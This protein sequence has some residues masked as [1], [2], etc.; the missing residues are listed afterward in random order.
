MELGKTTDRRDQ[1]TS[2]V[3]ELEE[4][5]EKLEGGFCVSSTEDHFIVLLPDGDEFEIFPR[6]RIVIY[7]NKLWTP[8]IRSKDLFLLDEIT[9][10]RCLDPVYAGILVKDEVDGCY[11]LFTALDLCLMAKV[12]IR[13]AKV[14]ETANIG[15]WAV[16]LSDSKVFQSLTE[17]FQYMET[18]V[19]DYE[20]YLFK[21]G[22]LYGGYELA[23]RLNIEC[24]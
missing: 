3:R 4:A 8:F 7:D 2:I 10:R 17:V 24:I 22:E 20:E 1:G 13:K 14:T 23:K 5:E 18:Y 19:C 21:N 11:R 12:R 9:V 16:D 15:K 6:M